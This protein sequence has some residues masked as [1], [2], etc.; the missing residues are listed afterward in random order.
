MSSVPTTDQR[1]GRLRISS[2][3][4][5]SQCVMEGTPGPATSSTTRPSVPI[6]SPA[7]RSTATGSPPMPTFPSA[8]SALCHCPSPGQDRQP[9]AELRGPAGLGLPHSLEDQIDAEN[10][11]A[12][13]GKCG[14]QAPRPQPMSRVQPEQWLN[15]ARS[16]GS[17]SCLHRWT[18]SSSGRSPR[19]SV[20]QGS[21]CKA[22]LKTSTNACTG[23]SGVEKLSRRL[24]GP[25]APL[26]GEPALG[27]RRH[28]DRGA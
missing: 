17:A 4:R 21:P 12:E 23:K 16:A 2:H 20:K 14:G 28:D 1:N 25:S 5:A 9:R 6:S 19:P 26:V 13:C 3:S 10:R 8:S 7:R 24:I 22:R 18:G 27:R 11:V 15:K